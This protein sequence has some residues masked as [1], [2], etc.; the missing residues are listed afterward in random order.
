M[1]DEGVGAAWTPQ[2]PGWRLAGAWVVATTLIGVVAGLMLSAQYWTLPPTYFAGDNFGGPLLIWAVGL[3]VLVGPALGLAQGLILERRKQTPGAGLWVLGTTLAVPLMLA[4]D[5]LS[6]ITFGPAVAAGL[7]G[8]LLGL[9][10]APALGRWR[11]GAAWWPLACALAFLL[12]AGAGAAVHAALPQSDPAAPFD[13]RAE[14]W[15]F[16]AGWSAGAFVFAVVT[17]GALFWLAQ[18]IRPPAAPRPRPRLRRRGEP[19]AG[20]ERGPESTVRGE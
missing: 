19:P 7:L 5:F 10:Q 3:V 18:D 12:A 2:R 17:A 16:A 4:A 14:G 20:V 15:R 11:R 9:A 8:A 6:P 1:S 13:P